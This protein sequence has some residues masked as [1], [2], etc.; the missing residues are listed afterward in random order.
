VTIITGTVHEDRYTFMITSLSVIL[1]MRN[2][3]DK[4]CREN[5]NTRVLFSN[6]FFFENRAVY[7]IMWEKYCKDRQATDENMPHVHVMLDN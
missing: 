1:R 3:S 5:Q 4:L 2:I 7:Q 6:F